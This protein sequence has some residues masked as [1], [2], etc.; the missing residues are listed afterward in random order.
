[1]H[2]LQEVPVIICLGKVGGIDV[3]I[4]TFAYLGSYCSIHVIT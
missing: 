3:K 4:F 2:K 1:M